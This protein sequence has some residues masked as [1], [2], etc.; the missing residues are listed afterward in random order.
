M[1]PLAISPAAPPSVPKAPPSG[2]PL[3]G[4]DD[5]KKTK[6]QEGMERLQQKDSQAE[7]YKK[8]VEK[9]HRSL[10]PV[11][12]HRLM[13]QSMMTKPDDPALLP[14]REPVAVH[15]NSAEALRLDPD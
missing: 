11:T 14:M 1:V 15:P 12:R 10:T 5:L 13:V 6:Y 9:R 4:M 2:K 3:D 8:D 7:D